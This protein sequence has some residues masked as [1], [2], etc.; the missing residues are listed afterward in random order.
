MSVKIIFIN[1]ELE[2]NEKHFS[3]SYKQQLILLSQ[4]AGENGHEEK[5]A[6]KLAEASYG[7]QTLQAA[8]YHKSTSPLKF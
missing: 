1:N 5:V 4:T 2:A 8:I 6:A 3:K 7:L